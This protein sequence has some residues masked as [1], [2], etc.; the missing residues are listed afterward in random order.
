[1]WQN[2]GEPEKQQSMYYGACAL[3]Y[4]A[5]VIYFG[6]RNCGLP[7]QCDQEFYTLKEFHLFHFCV[8]RSGVKPRAH[9]VR[10]TPAVAYV[11]NDHDISGIY[12]YQ[13]L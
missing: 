5:M 3:V 2:A 8:H 9:P 1:M 10:S 6:A 7:T 13:Y 4:F 11:D 12:I